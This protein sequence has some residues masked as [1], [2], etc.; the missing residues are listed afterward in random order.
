MKTFVLTYVYIT[1]D[2]RRLNVRDRHVHYL[3][4]LTD[5]GSLLVAGRLADG[6]PPGAIL[7]LLA[8]SWDDA[9]VVIEADP[10]VTEGIVAAWTLVEWLPALGLLAPGFDTEAS[11]PGDVD[12][13]K[14]DERA[15]SPE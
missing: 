15:A 2:W 6:Q 1:D 7:V 3:R 14:T 4:R 5:T 12:R 10:F 11:Q 13:N 8:E 9:R